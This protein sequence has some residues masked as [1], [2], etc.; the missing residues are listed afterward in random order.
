MKGND[1][2]PQQLMMNA[3][4]AVPV[5]LNVLKVQSPKVQINMLSIPQNALIVMPA[6]MSAQLVPAFLHS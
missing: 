3:S 1:P 5:K 2:W 4:L 6:R